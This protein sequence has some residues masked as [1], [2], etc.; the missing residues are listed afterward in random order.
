VAKMKGDNEL[1]NASRAS[2]QAEVAKM[3]GDNELANAS[4][5]SLQAEVAKMENNAEMMIHW[6]KERDMAL[7]RHGEIA[8]Y[9]SQHITHLQNCLVVAWQS[10]QTTPH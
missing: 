7:H 10:S 6:I 8:L 2:L 3:K 9:R 5:A 4:R 1:A